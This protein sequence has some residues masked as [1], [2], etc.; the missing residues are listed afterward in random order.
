M[1]TIIRK[2]EHFSL[3]FATILIFTENGQFLNPENV[4]Y[5]N[6]FS[7][8]IITLSVIYILTYFQMCDLLYYCCFVSFPTS[9]HIT[10]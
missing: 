9:F 6:I 2:E 3:N 1:L 5:Y 4:K 7:I 10:D 8:F